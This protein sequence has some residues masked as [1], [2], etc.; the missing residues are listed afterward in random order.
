MTKPIA[1]CLTDT[2]LKESNSHEN[3][4]IFNSAISLCKKYKLNTIYHLGD[5]FNSRKSQTLQV[6][7]DFKM[8]LDN[9]ESEGIVLNLIPGNHDKTD[10]SSEESFLDPFSTHP[11]LVLISRGYSFDLDNDI[12]LHFAPFFSDEIYRYNLE[13]CKNEALIDRKNYL[14]TH[15]GFEG[16][17][18]NSG[19]I[20]DGI[21][22]YE[23]KTFD[24]VFVGHYHDKQQVG[25][26]IHYIGSS[27]QHNFGE[28]P[29]KGVTVI[30]DDGSFETVE[31]D[32]KKYLKLE[33]DIDKLTPNE[34]DEILKVN[35]QSHDQ[36]R[37]ILVGTEEKIKSFNKQQLL[38]EGIS[39]E[40]KI[41][42]IE[43]KEI[44]ERTEPFTSLTLM[45][46]FDSFCKEKKLDSKV[47]KK[48]LTQVV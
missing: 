40:T 26:N 35:T 34:I 36:L 31:N 1:V 41:D 19:L 2:H 12:T 11:A 42:K 25:E 18:M 15:I 44:E 21:K 10:Y 43:K 7:I 17:R 28:T 32:I 6:L 46:A 20:V 30:Y 48:Y 47:G 8:I 16:A 24:K 22:P 45:T 27:L 38:V 9:L 37:V 29:D 13:Y 39:V 4:D 3:I 23:V 5:V 14:F 33:V